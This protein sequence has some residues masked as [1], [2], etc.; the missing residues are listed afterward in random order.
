MGF[1]G[2][3]DWWC[4]NFVDVIV[5]GLC[6]IV[7]GFEIVIWL[8]RGILN[9][10]ISL[11]LEFNDLVEVVNLGLVGNFGLLGLMNIVFGVF[12][13]NVGGEMVL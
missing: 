10:F 6:L 3:F 2:E 7:V 1:Y 8:C 12:F 13:G 9:S 5:V 4:F 11:L